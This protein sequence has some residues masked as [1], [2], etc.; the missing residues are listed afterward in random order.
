MSLKYRIAVTILVL[1]AVLI[2]V[3]LWFTLNHSMKEVRRHTAASEKFSLQLI[4]DLSRSALVTEDYAEV[5]NFI[6]ASLSDPRIVTAIV[7]DTRNRVVMATLPEFIGRPFPELN[8]DEHRYWR[9]TTIR[10]HSNRLG[11]LAVEFTDDALVAA[12]SETTR[13]GVIIAVVG[14][15][16]MAIVGIA[17]GYVLTRRLQVLAD[18]ADSINAGDMNV[19]FVVKGKDEVARLARAFDRMLQRLEDS[20][21]AVTRARDLLVAPT[22][23][24]SQGFV[25]WDVNDRLVLCNSRFRSLLKEIDEHIAVGLEFDDMAGWL[26]PH[27][28]A[29]EGDAMTSRDWL[30]RRRAGGPSTQFVIDLC[31][32]SK[33]WVNIRESRTRDGGTVAI[34]T[35]ITEDKMRQRALYASERRLRE[36]M[37][38]VFDGIITVDSNGL[39]ES[40]NQAAIRMFRRSSLDILGRP[41][42]DL[43]TTSVRSTQNKGSARGMSLTELTAAPMHTLREIGG[44]RRG[45]EVFPIDISVANIEIQGRATLICTVRDITDRKAA[46][47]EII[48]HATHDTLTSLPNRTLFDDRLATAISHAK[49]S[50]ETLAL[51]FLDVDR[52]KLI[53][54]MLG[55]PVGDAVLISVARRLLSQLRRSDTVARLGGDEFIMLLRDVDNSRNATSICQ[56]IVEAMRLPFH[57][58]DHDLHVTVS[59]GISMFPLDG[60][61]PDLLRK[62]ADVA[63]Y[64]SKSS[65]RNQVQ[66]F[67]SD[68]SV[69][70]DRQMTIETDLRQGLARQQFQ[71]F[72][73]PLIELHT[74]RMVGVE[75]LARWQHPKLGVIAPSQ[76]IPLA[77]AT[78]IISPLGLWIFRTACLQWCKWRDLSTPPLRMAINLSARQFR[79]TALTQQIADIIAETGVDPA[80]IEFELTESVLMHESDNASDAI[81]AFQSMGIGIVLDDFGTG[82]SSLS[83][84]KSYPIR[85]IKI[86]RSFVAD[87]EHN[88]NG[89]ALVKATTTMAQC[90]GIGV[91]A[92]GIETAGQAEILRSFGCNEGQGFLTGEPVTAEEITAILCSSAGLADADAGMTEHGRIGDLAVGAPPLRLVT[93]Q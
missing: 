21:A 22:E 90:M 49:R 6:R 73:Q 79:N 91:V 54:D 35:D 7:A 53:N 47:R 78:G 87:I 81:R 9:T 88:E 5:Q 31:L 74:G 77:E 70:S 45:G 62:H 51:A 26:R 44:I 80:S 56:N 18:A 46:E 64:R 89:A 27:I 43:L 66:L 76:F 71:L 34:C 11:I 2:A 59:L 93:R 83:H 69:A 92:E 32:R 17:I 39:I 58:L 37:A 75:A 14:I 23:A 19:P 86:D 24:M 4:A 29:F 60:E 40:V 48:F 52:F 72:Y 8:G 57:V 84:I 41:I 33:R 68:M 16:S 42:G 50:G 65:G 12:Y 13:L 10:G 28:V 82:C 85:R 20:M 61:T 55:H 63:L 30:A 25:L 1:Q 38:S 67:A 3:L 36:I 15:A